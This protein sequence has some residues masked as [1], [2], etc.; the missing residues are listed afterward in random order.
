MSNVGNMVS[1]FLVTIA[2]EIGVKGV[3]IGGFVC[4]AGGI[5]MLLVKETKKKQ[6]PMN[7]LLEDDS[8]EETVEKKESLV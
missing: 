8:L 5:S 6:M 2:D 1:P 4:I 3:F 7:P